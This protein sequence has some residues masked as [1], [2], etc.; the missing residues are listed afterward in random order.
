MTAFIRLW[1]VACLFNLLAHADLRGGIDALILR[2]AVSGVAA[3]AALRPAGRPFVVLA[4]GYAVLSLSDAPRINNHGLLMLVVHLYVL[5]VALRARFSGTTWDEAF[6]RALAPVLRGS[7][8]V[9]YGWAV[10]HKLNTGFLDPVMSCASSELEKLAALRPFGISLAALPR[11]AGAQQATILATLL[12]ESAIPLLLFLRR[13]RPYGA[14]LA[15]GFHVTLG[16]SYPAFS[17]TL[18]ALLGAFLPARA[19]HALAAPEHR[20]FAPRLA[21]PLALGC[22]PLFTLL[23]F[24]RR[25]STEDAAVMW[26]LPFLRHVLLVWTAWLVYRLAGPWARAPRPARGPA[27]TVAG[28]LVLALLVLIGLAPYLGL[29]STRSF[30]MYSNLYLSGAKSNHLFIPAGWQRVSSREPLVRIRDSSDPVLGALV[31]PSW[32]GAPDNDSF[33]TF[34]R[35]PLDSILRRPPSWGLPQEALRHRIEWLATHGERGIRLTYEVGGQV[36]STE[37]AEREPTLSGVSFW[38]R[39]FARYRAVPL[40]QEGLCM[41]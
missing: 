10:M 32:E 4:A 37:Q 18:W 2:V 41:W 7:V 5:G 1:A 14:A 20:P 3:Y 30:A 27:P 8:F 31:E 16:L 24:S 26:S 28:A 33:T 38:Q 21:I 15:V 6:E 23:W 36:Y 17:S 22:V 40:D 11:G 39:H 9:L 19:R 34:S 25:A 13:T 35:P 29:H 12:I